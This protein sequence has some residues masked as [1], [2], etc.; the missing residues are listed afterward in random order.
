MNNQNGETAQEYKERVLEATK[1]TPITLMELYGEI[2]Y[3]IIKNATDPSEVGVNMIEEAYEYLRYET[4][5]VSYDYDKATLTVDRAKLADMFEQA[6]P[7]GG[8]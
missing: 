5:A 2:A 7:M 6:F 4:D 1:M 3:S 8:K